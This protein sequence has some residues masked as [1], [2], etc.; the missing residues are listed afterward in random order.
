MYSDQF[1]K[2]LRLKAKHSY[3]DTK[4]DL[5]Y[6]LYRY[7]T[8]NPGYFYEYIRCTEGPGKYE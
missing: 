5:L 3:P 1:T 8:Y 6:E 2:L 4:G 7:V